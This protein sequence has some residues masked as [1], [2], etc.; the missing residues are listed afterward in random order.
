M[1]QE[2]QL[3][4]IWWQD[5]L[6]ILIRAPTGQLVSHALVLR[7][8]RIFRL[9]YP[10]VRLLASDTLATKSVGKVH[11]L[12]RTYCYRHWLPMSQ[13]EDSVSSYL[14]SGIINLATGAR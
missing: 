1:S 8:L 7:C 5:F 11:G 3:D 14:P 2:A 6:P 4:I 13:A 12:G 10:L 9:G